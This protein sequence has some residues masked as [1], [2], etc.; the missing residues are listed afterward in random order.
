[1]H[2]ALIDLTIVAGGFLLAFVGAEFSGVPHAGACAVLTGVLLATWRL[3]ANSESW[4]A[5]GLRAP[6]RWGRL[7]LSV[8][9]LYVLIVAGTL[10]VLEPLGNALAWPRLN[11]AGFA[12]V[13]GNPLQFANLLAI[14]WT[15]AAIG[16]E[17]LFRGF[18][19]ARMEKL[20]GHG[21]LP[22]TG[23]V[24]LQAAMFGAA[25]AYLGVRGIATAMLVGLIFGSWFVL[26][27]RNLLPLIL[28]HGLTDTISVFAIYAGVMP[29]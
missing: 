8:V 25:H 6:Q 17:L 4:R 10:L 16:E 3:K 26:R 11:I 19:L 12:Q 18:L 15:T 1:M 7:A 9:T 13:Q 5:L 14:T 23:A 21:A 22:A 28:T 2:A 27:G 20:L 29:Q 24:V